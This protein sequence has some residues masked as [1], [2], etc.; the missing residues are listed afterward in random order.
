MHVSIHT[1][2]C[3]HKCKK[4]D[5]AQFT[6][7]GV[8]NPELPACEASIPP[9]MYS[10]VQPFCVWRSRSQEMEGF[11]SLRHCLPIR[12]IAFEILLE[13]ETPFMLRLNPIVAM[14]YKGR[15]LDRAFALGGSWHKTWVWLAWKALGRQGLTSPLCPSLGSLDLAHPRQFLSALVISL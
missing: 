11:W 5:Y 6:W 15:C 12:R 14:A 10:P 3:T 9:V 13:W 4:T 2:T 8:S 1:S 7:N